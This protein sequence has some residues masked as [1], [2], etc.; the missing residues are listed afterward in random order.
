MELMDVI[1]QRRSV[2]QYQN[3]PVDAKALEAVLE[4]GRL[5]PSAR[6]DQS[7][8]CHVVEEPRLRQ[9]LAAAAQDQ[10]SAA[11]APCILVLTTDSERLMRCGQSAGT[12]DCAIALSYM[13][14]AA[15]E[16]DL[17]TCWLGNFAADEVAALLGLTADETVIALCPLGYPAEQPESKPRKPLDELV[18]RR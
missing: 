12:L 2:R 15:A 6:N 8:H 5:A 9:E 16:Q 18:S 14:L 1:K 4:A 13:M 7:W 17:G 10:S 3:R 11:E